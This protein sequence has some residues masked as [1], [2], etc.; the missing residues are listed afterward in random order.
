MIVRRIDEIRGTDRDIRGPTFDSRRLLLRRD[1]MGFSFHD[2]LIDA[3]TETLIWYVHHLEAVYCIEGEGEIE[4]DDGR[5]FDIRAGTLYGLDG[6]E[7]HM[8][9]ARTQMRMICVF[10]P[11]LNGNEVHDKDGVYPLIVDE[12]E[13]RV[14]NAEAG[15]GTGRPVPVTARD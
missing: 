15:D 13:T 8:L 6:H 3:G 1:G 14:A 4:L 7:K 5:R 2:T 11:P 12:P 10:N 9:R